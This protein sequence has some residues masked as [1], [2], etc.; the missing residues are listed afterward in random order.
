MKL[1]DL[2]KEQLIEEVNKL[3][4]RKKYGLVWEDKPEC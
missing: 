3:K 4:S 2:T 1:T